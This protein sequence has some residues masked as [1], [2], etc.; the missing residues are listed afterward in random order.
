[1]IKSEKRELLNSK[2]LFI[3]DMDGTIYLSSK[4][5]EYAIDFVKSLRSHNKKVLFFTNNSSRSGR[6]Y[7]ERLNKMGFAPNK[8][9]VL[10][11]GDVTAS[12]ISENRKNVPVYLIGTAELWEV[13]SQY[14][15]NLINDSKGNIIKNEHPLIVVS[16]FDTELTYKKLELGCTFIRNGA[17]YY[18]T[19]PD[20]NCPT[21]NGY[22]PD[23]G[24]IAAAITAS[25]GVSPIYFGKPH[26]N[27]IDIIKKISK[28]KEAEMCIFGDRLY[29]DIAFG[30]N[31]GISAFLML[32]G[33][34]TAKDAE[35]LSDDF[36]PD[37]IFE[38]FKETLEIMYG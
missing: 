3:F 19:H 23:S 18:S 38:N 6:I 21:N 37:I 28:C 11:S 20:F 26:K 29:T 33:E 8:D 16:G 35:K 25:T 32:T 24:S 15:V 4:P 34:G 2:E 30:K 1:M 10:T 31:N 36:R 5:F 9:E 17:D 22:I 27:A 13:F 14:G 7:Y 12:Y